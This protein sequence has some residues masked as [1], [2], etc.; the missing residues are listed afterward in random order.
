MATH[1]VQ[2]AHPGVG[3]GPSI[4]PNYNAPGLQALTPQLSPAIIPTKILDLK[5]N[6]KSLRFGQDRPDGG[7]SNAPY[8]WTDIP[9]NAS[10]EEKFIIDAAKYSYDFPIR[11]GALAPI[12]SEKDFLRISKF[13][14]DAPRGPLFL[15]KQELLQLSNPKIETGEVLIG[16]GLENTR[17]YNFGANTL[18]QI[19]ATAFG[20]HFDRTGAT[21][22]IDDSQKYFSIVKNKPKEENRLVVLKDL[23]INLNTPNNNVLINKL[24]ISLNDNLLFDYWGGPGSVMGAI[25]RTI[26]PRSPEKQSN[27]TYEGGNNSVSYNGIPE[28]TKYFTFLNHTFQK[29]QYNK[30]LNNLPN[31]SS[32]TDE[33]P[34]GQI[35]MDFRKIINKEVANSTVLPYSDYEDPKIRVESRTQMGNPGKISRSRISYTSSDPDTIDKIN[36]LPL[37]REKDFVPSEMANDLIKFRFETI[38][39]INPTNGVVIAFRAFLNE[40]N[41]N[42]SADWESFRYTG[43]GENFYTYNGFRREMNF[44]FKI[45][46]QSR[47]EMK[48]LY[49]K[50]N[51]LIAQMAPDY[52]TIFM[53]GP[54]IRLTIGDYIVQQPGFINSL[55]I[56]IDNNTPWEIALNDPDMYELP[57]V[58]NVQAS[59]TPIHSF[60]VR[61]YAK[62]PYVT[63][64][65]SDNKFLKD[66]NI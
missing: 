24:G 48:P 7:S 14:A 39:N 59:F 32:N 6:L 58:L 10:P 40:I 45:A 25:G 56:T 2:P 8:V 1:P 11:G 51:Y 41:D 64:P 49:Q 53:S 13:L 4:S 27:F 66:I 26:I 9:D 60:L 37:I 52:D 34:L 18:A 22:I 21:P 17:F 33:K 46:A 3:G 19:P 20:I 29:Y 50:F 30:P 38:D 16:N 63:P 12:N 47:D 62:A 28:R 42:P 65:G 54:M 5:T 43:R 61:R 23:K 57:Q 44:S 55:S 35:G 31:N 36:A 15:A